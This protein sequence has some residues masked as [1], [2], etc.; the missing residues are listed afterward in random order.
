MALLSDGTISTLGDLRDY[1]SAIFELASTEQIDL[2]RKLALAKQEIEVELTDFLLRQSMHQADG[3]AGARPD[4]GRVVVT[5][6]LRQWHTYHA[7]AL[8]YRDAYSTHYND[9]YLGKWKGYE[10]LASEA[11]RKSFDIGVGLVYD[12]I[13]KAAPARLSAA[14]GSSPGGTY[15]VRVAWTGAAGQ[16]GE[17]GDPVYLTVTEGSALAVEATDASVNATGWNV[18]AGI[19]SDSVELQ[20]A[21]PLPAGTNWVMPPEGIARGRQPGEGQPAAY[22]VTLRRVLQRG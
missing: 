16:E 18:Y 12:P 4:L 22:F 1:E 17:P 10:R 15:W 20:N 3:S 14:A 11:S 9:R 5:P 13:P 7:L 6:A 8:S 19:T 2:S 21:T